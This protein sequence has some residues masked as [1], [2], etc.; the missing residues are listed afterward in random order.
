V[1]GVVLPLWRYY[2]IKKERMMRRKIEIIAEC[3]INHNGDMRL[4]TKMIGLA[5]EC[6]ADVAK[7]QT[8]DAEQLIR[9]VPSL[10]L[11]NKEWV[12][13]TELS[14]D[15]LFL[16]ANE[17]E[18]YGIE[19]MSSVFDERSLRW[20][21]E[22]GVKRY[23]L[24]SAFATDV[25]LCGKIK[26]TRKE[27]IA[28]C[29]HMETTTRNYAPTPWWFSYQCP[30]PWV[31]VGHPHVKLLYCVPKYPTKLEELELPDKFGFTGGYWGFSDHTEDILASIV[32]MSRGARL[33]EKHFTLDTEK[34]GPDHFM[35][36]EPPELDELCDTRDE[37]ELIGKWGEH[38]SNNTGS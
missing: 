16:L 30:Q 33:I 11:Y 13:K 21:E 32:A 29:G 7:F 20:L 2:S 18:R 25:E 17:C 8:F 24:A 6:G 31:C 14:K 22:V 15:N 3:G 10:P 36:I 1:I 4:A 5:Q 28:S 38:V 12:R 19:F 27:I 37:I 35:S 26:E 34:E 9:K 23:K